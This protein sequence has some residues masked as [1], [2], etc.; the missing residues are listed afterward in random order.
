MIDTLDFNSF[1]GLSTSGDNRIAVWD[2][3]GLG[4]LTSQHCNSCGGIH[5]GGELFSGV[6]PY[7]DPFNAVGAQ[8]AGPVP[9]GDECG[10]AGLSTGRHPPKSCPEG[11]I[12][13]NGDF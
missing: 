10:A 4:A 2:W 13:T 3:T 5:F 11:G 1:A 7:N 8:R 12:E 6:E 9:L